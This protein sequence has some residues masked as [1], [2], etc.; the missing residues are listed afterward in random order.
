MI[1]H[2]K[3]P[4]A[5]AIDIIGGKWKPTILL[6]LKDQPR[7]FNELR[8]LVPG[9]TQRMLTL[10]LRALEDDGIITRKIG[11]QVPPHVEYFFTER[12]RTLGPALEAL[13]AWGEE[14]GL[15]L[16]A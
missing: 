12:G 16:R 13:E 10:Q 11:D 4:V 14:H 7:R 6:H 3:C 1:H 8:R 2:D 5:T 9:I 15:A